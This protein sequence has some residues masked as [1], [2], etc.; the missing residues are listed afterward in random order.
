M[1]VAVRFLLHLKVLLSGSLRASSVCVCAPVLDFAEARNAKVHGQS[2]SPPA[3]G[4]AVRAVSARSLSPKSRSAKIRSLC[5]S[6]ICC[7]CAPY[8][9]RSL[10]T[11]LTHTHRAHTQCI[12]RYASLFR[13]GCLFFVTSGLVQVPLWI[14]AH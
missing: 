10:A 4:N 11:R 2:A 13:F 7:M 14:R 9:H 12:R 1:F 6:T 8:V 3:H 5:L